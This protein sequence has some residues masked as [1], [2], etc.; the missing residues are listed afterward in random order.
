MS[1]LKDALKVMTFT[2]HCSITIDAGKCKEVV[3]EVANGAVIYRFPRITIIA[4]EDENEVYRSG[5]YVFF[6][7]HD[8]DH[9]R[10]FIKYIAKTLCGDYSCE[11]Q[12][13][14]LSV[15]TD[16]ASLL[17]GGPVSNAFSSDEFTDEERNEYLTELSKLQLSEDEAI[18]KIVA[19]E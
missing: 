9:N 18:D 12:I 3:S 15:S 17:I 6:C 2:N 4:K 10:L 11:F 5:G 1:E 19:H 7:E 14:K 13:K 8:A 16:P